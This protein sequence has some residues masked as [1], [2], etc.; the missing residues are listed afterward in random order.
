MSLRSAIEDEKR[1]REAGAD[2]H[3]YGPWVGGSKAQ[4]G[5]PGTAGGG[6]EHKHPGAIRW[7]QAPD[8]ITKD[9]DAAAARL[10][11][12]AD[13]NIRRSE[14]SLNDILEGGRFK[15]TFETGRTGAIGGMEA[16]GG[17]Y[18]RARAEGEQRVFGLAMDA[19]ASSRPIYAYATDKG[20]LGPDRMSNYGSV[21]ITLKPSVRSRATVT[22]E[23]NLGGNLP[24]SPF[25]SPKG[26]STRLGHSA[27]M[28]HQQGKV[29][30]STRKYIG[31]FS[32]APNI[33][34]LSQ[35]PEVAIHGGVKVSDIA[36]VT[37]DSKPAKAT[38]DRLD[39]LS[40]PW[41]QK[42]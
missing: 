38:T 14:D 7:E 5:H 26:S 1:L 8:D 30:P 42:G 4:G 11:A 10:L 12:D 15:T 16:T 32:A 18:A 20:S 25:T 28:Q 33:A 24:A 21:A 35:P 22:F 39:A 17:Q 19:P 27:A 9:M 6:G 29:Y 31:E 40:I 41:S 3:P 36:R 2:D 34:A 23:D 13:I 37:F